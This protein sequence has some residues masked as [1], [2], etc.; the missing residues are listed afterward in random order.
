MLYFIKLVHLFFFL[1]ILLLYILE[2]IIEWNKN[3]IK[4]FYS[5]TV[6]KIQDYIIS[7]YLPC[8][9]KLLNQYLKS[10]SY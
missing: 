1:M 3:I 4:Y 9:K 10:K 6:N 5:E 2:L 7:N 8:F